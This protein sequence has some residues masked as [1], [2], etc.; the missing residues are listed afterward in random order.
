MPRTLDYVYANEDG[1]RVLHL[2]SW[3]VCT[4]IA[5]SRAAG[6]AAPGHLPVNP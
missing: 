2:A 3:K 6:G 4:A 1:D 5:G